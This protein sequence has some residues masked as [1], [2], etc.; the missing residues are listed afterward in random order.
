M[1]IRL[2]EFII[3]SIAFSM[4]VVTLKVS[5]CYLVRIFTRKILLRNPFYFLPT[6]NNN[7]GRLISAEVIQKLLYRCC[8]SARQSSQ[9]VARNVCSLKID[10]TF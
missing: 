8:Y 7:F 3:D 2:H 4:C 5:Y 1:F 9:V 6:W 10:L